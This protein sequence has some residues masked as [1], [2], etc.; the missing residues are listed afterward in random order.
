MKKNADFRKILG[1]Q[2]AEAAPDRRLFYVVIAA[3]LFV[4]FALSFLTAALLNGS[5]KALAAGGKGAVVSATDTFNNVTP[6]DGFVYRLTDG[7]VANSSTDFTSA[8]GKAAIIIPSKKTPGTYKYKLSAKPSEKPYVVIDDTAYTIT[9]TV[10]PDGTVSVTDISSTDSTFVYPTGTVKFAHKFANSQTDITVYKIW[11]D[12]SNNDGL[13]PAEAS[14]DLLRN[15]EKIK[16]LKISASKDKN[17]ATEKDLDRYVISGADVKEYVYT[18]SEGKVNGYTPVC[19]ASGSDF[20]VT[21]THKIS[22]TDIIVKKVWD[23]SDDADGKR[24]KSLK[25]TLYAGNTKKDSATIGSSDKWTKTWKDLPV[26][27]KGEKITYSVE[28]EKVADYTAS[29]PSFDS[30]TGTFTLT[31]SHKAQSTSFS[32]KKVWDDKDDQD[33]LRSSTVTVQLYADGTPY[34][35]AVK[36]NSARDWKYTWTSLPM[37]KSDSDTQKVLYTVVETD[38]PMGYNP[39]YSEDTSV[40]TN[41]HEPL[42]DTI[43]GAAVWNDSG[44]ADK[45]PEAVTAYLTANGKV[46][47]GSATLN[48]ANGWTESWVNMP[49]YENG[50]KIDYSLKITAPD[51]YEQDVV[52]NDAGNS[53]VASFTYVPP[54]NNGGNNG[55]NG[56]GGSSGPKTGDDSMLLKPLAIVIFLLSGTVIAGVAV[57]AVRRRRKAK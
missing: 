27:D 41:K 5:S 7:S 57:T 12:S 23:D 48:S 11:D 56:G 2:S 28:E 38:C 34:G 15:G 33:G 30:K 31:N 18:V 55:S 3:A 37:Y 9:V 26:Y 54:S 45:R 22:T 14:I 44:Y 21:N 42:T 8:A 49:I 52:K 24:P 32:V 39:S 46:V 16:T 47:G 4:V 53:I 19:K 1:G 17:S 20:V 35:D 13:R 43:K 36:L 6:T 25:I 51:G 29:K 40:I 10:K 50:K